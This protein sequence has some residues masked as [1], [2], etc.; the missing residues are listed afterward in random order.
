MKKQS[1]HVPEYC[2]LCPE[3]E[4]KGE[5][6]SGC[7]MCCGKIELTNENISFMSALS[8][9]SAGLFDGMGGVNWQGIALIANDM[10]A[11]DKEVFLRK[12]NA[13]AQTLIA[14]RKPVGEKD[15][16]KE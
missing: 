4:E 7:N 2:G 11:N 6:Q 16:S 15:A 8:C 13:Y 14:G 10:G 5:W 1:G 9:V 12:F 3:C